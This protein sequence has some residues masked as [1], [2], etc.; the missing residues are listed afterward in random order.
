MF[1]IV[2]VGG[3]TPPPDNQAFNHRPIAGVE[4]WIAAGEQNGDA[5]LVHAIE[6]DRFLTDDDLHETEQIGY[7]GPCGRKERP[8][9][10]NIKITFIV[11]MSNCLD[12]QHIL[13]NL[14]AALAES[15]AF[16]F[17]YE[18]F[19]FILINPL[20]VTYAYL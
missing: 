8:Q 2:A 7:I 20:E 15:P 17:A 16:L 5:G 1:E 13:D 19:Y 12:I 10:L 4:A 9:A 18:L 11:F 6:I 3:N 14:I